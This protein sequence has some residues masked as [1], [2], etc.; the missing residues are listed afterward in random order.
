MPILTEQ[1]VTMPVTNPDT[2]RPSRTFTYAGKIDRV[3][4]TR[5]IDFKSTGDP[6]RFIKVHTIGHQIDLYALAILHGGWTI[7]EVE[8]R[9]V[10]TPTIKLCGKDDNDPVKYQARCEQWIADQP[11]GLTE[12][13]L[14]MNTGR[15]RRAQ[16]CLWQSSKRILENRQHNRWLQNPGACYAYERAC[17][18]LPLCEAVANDAVWSWIAQEQYEVGPPHPELGDDTKYGGS[19]LTY[20]AISTLAQCEMKYYWRFELGLRKRSDYSEALWLGSAMHAGLEGYAKGGAI[21]AEIA[22]G[23]WLVQHP[24]L[25]EDMAIKQDQQTAKARAMV[26][27]VARRW[28]AIGDSHD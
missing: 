27:A 20:T 25:G 4:G 22:I 10:R 6:A 18:Y 24:I 21:G 19:T 5:L 26:N 15:L 14:F 17:P 7:M 3:K 16:H 12:H 9:L 23:D 1:I 13:V 8:Y 2:G 28:P 11:N